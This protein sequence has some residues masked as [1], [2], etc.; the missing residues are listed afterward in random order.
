MSEGKE[1]RRGVT[2]ANPRKN[3]KESIGSQPQ[4]TRTHRRGGGC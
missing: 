4:L 3:T 1:G 2:Q